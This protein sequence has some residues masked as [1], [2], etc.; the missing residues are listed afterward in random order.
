[1]AISI[2]NLITIG[3]LLKVIG[4]NDGLVAYDCGAPGMNITTLKLNDVQSCD[5]TFQEPTSTTSQIQLLQSA[6]S[7]PVRILQCKIEISRLIHHCGMHS[8]SSIVKNGFIEYMKEVPREACFELH[9]TQRYI[10]A[11]G[12]FEGLN[13]N[14]TTNRAVTFAGRV[15]ESGSC[16][17]TFY[18]DPYGSWDNV[19]VQGQITISLY[20][21]YATIITDQDEVILRS[22][23]RCQYSKT[24]CIDTEGG[25]TFWREL[26]ADNCNFDKYLM[27][28][29]GTGT[30]LTSVDKDNKKREIQMVTKGTTTFALE[31][32]G[33]FEKCGYRL[34]R[35]EHSRLFIVDGSV[36]HHFFK[37]NAMRVG[38]MDYVLYTNAKVVYLE[39]H[40]QAQIVSL[41]DNLLKQQCY[42]ERRMLHNLLGLAHVA[43]TEF[44]FRL[45]QE[46]GYTAHVGGEVVRIAKC[47]PVEVKLRRIDQCFQE[48][49]V[50]RSGTPMF[51]MPRS[52][53]LVKT[54]EQINCNAAIAPMYI[55][56]N[57]WTILDPKPGYAE[58][59]GEI[60]TKIRRDWEYVSPH[61][62]ANSGIYSPEA[63]DNLRDHMMFPV[64]KPAVLHTIAR[65]AIGQES[66]NQGIYVNS[67]INEKAIKQTFDKFWNEI[68]GFF[69]VLGSFGVTA[70]GVW[71]FVR[72]TKLIIDTLIHGYALH[73]IYGWSL[74]LIGAIWDSVTHLLIILK[75]KSNEANNHNKEIGESTELQNLKEIDT[76]SSVE[77]SDNF[78]K[79]YPNAMTYQVGAEMTN[80]ATP[81]T[82]VPKFDKN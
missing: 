80:Y 72:G 70:F 55:L 36:N 48:L 77:E 65:E 37:R 81:S 68:Y 14:G 20:D 16:S 41:Y 43:P 22:G 17:G 57:K 54:A 79:I 56:D 12:I 53:V 49:P 13:L 60:T 33:S 3:L 2:K 51:M 75:N 66:V 1:M 63:L 40:V 42:L 27:L 44:A 26:L 18:S 11:T 32:K 34:L 52:R 58:T 59:P 19:V 62:L 25:Y 38:E 76:K 28:Y 7:F 23:I 69:N 45:M 30:K 10:T 50:N 82:S 8:H 39:H 71:I 47:V 31:I 5:V 67:L 46:A 6:E 64:E 24:S 9:R 73:S 74:C 4:P 78:T 61:D 15:D 35:T 21:Y 29:E